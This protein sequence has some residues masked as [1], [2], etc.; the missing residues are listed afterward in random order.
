MSISLFGAVVFYLYCIWIPKSL[1]LKDIS[2]VSDPVFGSFLV[3]VFGIFV[4]SVQHFFNDK[5]YTGCYDSMIKTVVQCN[6][7]DEE[8]FV[9][10]QKYTEPF[11]DDLMEYWK[12]N[13]DDD[14]LNAA[15]NL[16][17][18][19]ELVKDKLDMDD[20]YRIVPDKVDDKELYPDSDD[21]EKVDNNDLFN[22][23]L[24]KKKRLNVQQ[25]FDEDFLKP[26]EKAKLLPA[27]PMAKG[28]DVMFHAEA[29]LDSSMERRDKEANPNEKNLTNLMKQDSDVSIELEPK[30]PKLIIINEN[31]EDESKSKR[32]IKPILKNS[33][34]FIEDPNSKSARFDVKDSADPKAKNTIKFRDD[35]DNKSLKSSM[36]KSKKKDQKVV[37]NEENDDDL[38]SSK[39]KKKKD[40]DASEDP[41]KSQLT[42]VKEEKRP[43][44]KGKSVDIQFNES[45]Y[46]DDDLKS[47]KSKKKKGEKEDGDLRKKNLSALLHDNDDGKSSTKLKPKGSSRK[48]EDAADPKEGDK[49]LAN[50]QA[51]FN[52]DDDLKSSKSKKQK[53]PTEAE[54]NQSLKPSTLGVDKKAEK[55][56]EPKKEQ[57][58]EFFDDN[59]SSKLSLKSK[60]KREDESGKPS[61]KPKNE[62]LS[63]PKPESMLDKIMNKKKPDR[64]EFED[65]FLGEMSNAVDKD[66][67]QILN[68]S[69]GNRCLRVRSK[70]GFEQIPG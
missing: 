27:K 21:E 13:D 37:F 66:K 25:D 44:E 12:N 57:Q 3:F 30:V 20:L 31:G 24:T 10:E 55:S 61:K 62:E 45:E 11:M 35:D 18:K 2:D 22:D 43:N 36:S 38:K 1:S 39:S 49:R 65:D 64:R 60:K 52:Y 42:V 17:K 50:A 8:M 53:K 67:V 40:K 15:A 16:Q 26:K 28:Q 7:M 48:I 63:Y 33:V 29:E 23:N 6:F 51:L 41:K 9:G 14:K 68:A 59:K 69:Q 46:Q 54:D 4:T 58:I 56:K 70:H 32:D 34:R 19:K 47:S 5:S